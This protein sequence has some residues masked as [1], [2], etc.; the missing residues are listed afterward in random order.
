MIRGLYTSGI[1]MATQMKKLDVV[2]NNLANVNTTGY[3]KDSP[4]ISSFPDILMT[5]INDRDQ[6]GMMP[7]PIGN[8]TLGAQI[9]EI[10]TDFSQGSFIRTDDRFN[11]AIQGDGFFT[12]TTPDGQERYT[13]DGSFIVSQD[14]QL[15]TK[16]GNLVMGQ[17]GVVRLGD[18]FLTRRREVFIDDTG[19]INI[20]GTL[21]DR[22]NI[23]SFEDQAGLDKVG[24]NLFQGGGNPGP[25]NGKVIQGFLEDTNVNPVTAMVDL[26]TVSRAYEANQK[27]VQVH[28]SLM[29]KAANE[30]GKA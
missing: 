30:V 28:D 23:V 20:E 21:V 14:G 12:V 26:I 27:M 8:V 18:E 25:F 9:D 1:G 17:N 29:G 15:K 11:V 6:M 10:Y 19:G 2:S 4:I 13:R 16:E 5:K 7:K 3:K 24:D 22:L